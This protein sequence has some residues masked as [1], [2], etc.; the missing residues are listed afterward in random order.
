MIYIE[1]TYKLLPAYYYIDN[2]ESDRNI[3]TAKLQ[4]NKNIPTEPTIIENMIHYNIDYAVCHYK[5]RA[6]PQFSINPLRRVNYTGL[7]Y[8]KAIIP[9]Q[10]EFSD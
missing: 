2:E 6:N 7:P 3:W 8:Y 9:P 5:P 10:R 1:E 4:C